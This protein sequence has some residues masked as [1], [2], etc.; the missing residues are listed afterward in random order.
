MPFAAGWQRKRD[1]IRLGSK[2]DHRFMRSSLVVAQAASAVTVVS[3]VV[4][5]LVGRTF[6]PFVGVVAAWFVVVGSGSI[7]F[8]NAMVGLNL[9][10]ANVGTFVAHVV[11][12]FAVA[13]R[14]LLAK[15][16]VV[17]FVA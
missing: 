6:P 16:A 1:I 13:A 9:I 11:G 14:L 10:I 12:W 15:S 4:V 3:V 7:V 2:S 17:A 8:I 5:G